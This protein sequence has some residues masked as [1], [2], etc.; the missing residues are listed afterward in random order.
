M[1]PATAAKVV[2]Y[3]TITVFGLVMIAP[4]LYLL[5]A[6][7]MTAEDVGAY[8]PHFLPPSLSFSNYGE[9]YS[10]L[11]GR[12]ILNSFVFALGVVVLQLVLGL[13][14]GFAL[15]KI[16]FRGAIAVMVLFVVPMFLPNNVAIIPLYIVTR[17]L[18][19]VNTYAGMILPIA[20]STAFS[21]LLFRQFFVNLPPGL[22]E[23]ARID[24]AGWFRVLMTI[25]VPLS[26]PAVAAFSSITFLNAWN[27]YI[28]PLIVAPDPKLQVMPVAL[29]PLA[30]G[31]LSTI[32][33]NIG[34]A[35]AVISILPVVVAF[36]LAQRWFV[37]GIVGT[38]LE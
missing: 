18:G 16:P 25:V 15:A 1:R 4:L 30:R 29:A 37:R 31:Q 35:A 3:T 34:L 23:A 8:P 22:I 33:P 14:A 12:T 20:G 6:S 11:T 26:R 19:I 9:A 2:R 27:M 10:Y 24:G 17:E 5:S 21:T 13:P 28:W 32:T 36:L 38:G 7:L